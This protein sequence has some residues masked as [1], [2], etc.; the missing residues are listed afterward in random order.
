MVAGDVHLIAGILGPELQNDKKLIHKSRNIGVLC[1]RT[2][3]KK[4]R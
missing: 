3:K 2:K 1:T 4:H